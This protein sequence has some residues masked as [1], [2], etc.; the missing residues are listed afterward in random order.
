MTRLELEDMLQ[1]SFG[2]KVNSTKTPTTY[3]DGST[4]PKRYYTRTVTG[5]MRLINAPVTDHNEELSTV[6]LIS[7]CSSLE[8]PPRDIAPFI[9]GFLEHTHHTAPGE[10]EA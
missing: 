9:P 2:V 3:E 1:T 7:I 10:M 4:A 8:I 6:T 5:R